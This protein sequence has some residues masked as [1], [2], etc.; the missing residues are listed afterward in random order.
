MNQFA[1]QEQRHKCRGCTDSNE[2]EWGWD[3]VGDWD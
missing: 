1:G 3:K 2:R